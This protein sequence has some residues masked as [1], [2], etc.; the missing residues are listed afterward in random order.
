MEQDGPAVLVVAPDAVQRGVRLDPVVGHRLG[1]E[2]AGD[3]RADHLGGGAAAERAGKR[4]NVA[5]VALGGGAQ[6][7]ELGVGKF[8]HRI[9][10]V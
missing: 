4:K 3:Q 1:D 6:D 2:P 5:V 7:Q 8:G 9:V 10:I